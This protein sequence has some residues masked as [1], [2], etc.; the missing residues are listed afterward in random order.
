MP[1][2]L[3]RTSSL[4]APPAL[5][6]LSPAH[7]QPSPRPIQVSESPGLGPAAPLTGLCHHL[8]DS[9]CFRLCLRLWGLLSPLSPSYSEVTCPPCS[10]ITPPPFPE[11]SALIQASLFHTETRARVSSLMSRPS[12]SP[13]LPSTHKCGRCA[14]EN[15]PNALRT[16]SSPFW[17]EKAPPHPHLLTSLGFPLFWFFCRQGVGWTRILASL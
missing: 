6:L 8:P 17:G 9:V 16:P 11:V 3:F 5:P 1:Q 7:P 12:L 13:L 2:C 14:A 4:E 10:L 15:P